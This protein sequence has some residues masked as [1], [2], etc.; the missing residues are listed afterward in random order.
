MTR[1][2]GGTHRGR[3]LPGPAHAMTRGLDPQGFGRRG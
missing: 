3:A 2:L 1:G